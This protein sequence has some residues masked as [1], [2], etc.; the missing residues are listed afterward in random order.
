MNI[1]SLELKLTYRLILEETGD[2]T[3]YIMT[4]PAVCSQSVTDE[5]IF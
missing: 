2:L 5:F 3:A 1:I 4:H